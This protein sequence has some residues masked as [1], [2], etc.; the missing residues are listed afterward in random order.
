[1]S[2]FVTKDF[3]QKYPLFFFKY[4]HIGRGTASEAQTALAQKE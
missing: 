2:I 1:M 4:T 3:N